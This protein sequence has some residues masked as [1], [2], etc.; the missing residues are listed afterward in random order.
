MGATFHRIRERLEVAPCLL[1]RYEESREAGEGAFGICSFWAAEHLARGG[2]SLDEAKDWF[3]RLLPYANDVGIF[4]EE[5]DPKTREPLGN[6]PQA[7]THVGLI[8]AA[9]AIEERRRGTQKPQPIDQ[10]GP[11]IGPGDAEVQL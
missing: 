1:Y 2:G 4:A 7:F 6:V 9:L 3:E 10:T 11:S 8:S 5:I